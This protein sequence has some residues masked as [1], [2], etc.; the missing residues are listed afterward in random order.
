MWQEMQPAK[1]QQQL[2]FLN[3]FIIG[4]VAFENRW[5]KIV[6]SSRLAQCPALNEQLS[7]F[8]QAMYCI[9]LKKGF[10]KSFLVYVTT[11]RGRLPC[12]SSNFLSESKRSSFFCQVSVCQ[13]RLLCKPQVRLRGE[14]SYKSKETLVMTHQKGTSIFCEEDCGPAYL[15]SPV[16]KR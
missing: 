9:P 8:K 15:Q 6:S 5:M 13:P 12:S 16:L 3:R 10:Q 14:K 1:P 2:Q 4:I 7:I 11:R